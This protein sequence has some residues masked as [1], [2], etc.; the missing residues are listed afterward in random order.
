MNSSSS[1]EEDDE[2]EDD[3]EEDD[4]E[5]DDEEEDDEEEDDEE[6]DDEEEEEDE[7][8]EAFGSSQSAYQMN[9]RM[10]PLADLFDAGTSNFAATFS[11]Y[12]P[13]FEV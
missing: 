7:E 13:D 5:E 10:V 1:E 12:G 2:E 3:Q 8:E 11:S 4:R 6:E 9:K